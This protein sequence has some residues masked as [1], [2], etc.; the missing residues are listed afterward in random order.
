MTAK[1]GADGLDLFGDAWPELLADVA[2]LEPEPGGR[3]VKIEDQP[4]RRKGFHSTQRLW[5]SEVAGGVAAATWPAELA[6]Q[7]RYLYSRGLGSRLVTTAIER[8]W[9]V[10]ASPHIAY[11]TSPSSRRLYMLPGPSIA[12][13]DYV[14][15]WEG[16]DGF[17][18][19]GGNYS[20]EAATTPRRTSSTN[21]G[22]G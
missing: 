12:P 8:G 18:R 5:I 2:R 3:W 6:A 1:I 11:R 9:K 22:R 13:H 20:Q 14:S 19:I 16:K 7:A 4:G 17:R 21:C 10:E 15:L